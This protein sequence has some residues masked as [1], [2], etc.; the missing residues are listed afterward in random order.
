MNS[1]D[2]SYIQQKYTT[3]INLPQTTQIKQSQQIP[4]VNHNPV[5]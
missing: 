3:Y 4:G 5:Q 1:T 2:T